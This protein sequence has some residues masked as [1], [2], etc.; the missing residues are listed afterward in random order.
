MTK[1][2]ARRGEDYGPKEEGTSM[3]FVIVLCAVLFGLYRLVNTNIW[4]T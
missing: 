3:T 1:K 4:W 2:D